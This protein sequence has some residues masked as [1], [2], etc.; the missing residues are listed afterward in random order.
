MQ[1]LRPLRVYPGRGEPGGPELLTAQIDYLRT[2]KA[3]VEAASPR[4]E[5]DETRRR[6]LRWPKT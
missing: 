6:S 3:T 1:G 5:I 4:G 2:A